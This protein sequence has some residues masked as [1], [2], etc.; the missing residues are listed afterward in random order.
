MFLEAKPQQTERKTINLVFQ[1]VRQWV[2][3]CSVLLTEAEFLIDIVTVIA[4][5]QI[6]MDYPDLVTLQR[7]DTAFIKVPMLSLILHCHFVI[8]A[9]D[10]AIHY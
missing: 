7:P 1:S 9:C 6:P 3:A 5:S 2:A 4:K 8:A 10:S